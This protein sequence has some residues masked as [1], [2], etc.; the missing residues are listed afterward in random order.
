MGTNRNA[1]YKLLHE[2]RRKLKKGL[3]AHGFDSSEMLALYGPS[4][5]DFGST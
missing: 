2:A 5:K 4:R 1:V 3:M